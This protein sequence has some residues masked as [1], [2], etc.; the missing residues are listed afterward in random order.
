M[1]LYRLGNFLFFPL[2]I[3]T[4]DVFPLQSVFD[5]TRLPCR[6]VHPHVMLQKRYTDYDKLRGRDGGD[7]PCQINKNFPRRASVRD[8]R[9]FF[10]G[11]FSD[12][13][14]EPCTKY[15]LNKSYVVTRRSRSLRQEN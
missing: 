5:I 11:E 15:S 9:T 6:V 14:A 12:V 10:H 8:R 13:N 7:G 2:P 4:S 1:Y 3:I